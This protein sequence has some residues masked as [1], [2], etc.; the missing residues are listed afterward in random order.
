[1][2][3]NPTCGLPKSFLNNKKSKIK[4]VLGGLPFS[5]LFFVSIVVLFSSSV[6]P[7]F[8]DLFFHLFN[9]SF[10]PIF[11]FSPTSFFHFFF[12]FSHPVVVPA[13]QAPTLRKNKYNIKTCFWPFVRRFW[14][15]VSPPLPFLI[16]FSFLPFPFLHI[17]LFISIFSLSVSQ[18]CTKFMLKIEKL[19]W[20]LRHYMVVNFGQ[21][22]SGRWIQAIHACIYINILS[23]FP[24]SFH[25]FFQFVPTHFFPLTWCLLVFG[26][27]SEYRPHNIRKQ[28]I[29]PRLT[30]V[31]DA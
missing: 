10:F 20:C 29:A 27:L 24:I 23:Y 30:D 13:L 19:W 6:F 1:M 5:L 4:E 25:T 21:G 18:C 9:F 22:D 16:S 15:P 11:H 8:F 17:F 26:P 3:F 31:L 12:C 14:S 2:G 28:G 7:H